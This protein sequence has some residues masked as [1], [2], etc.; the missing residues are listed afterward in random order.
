LRENTQETNFDCLYCID[1]GAHEGELFRANSLASKMFTVYSKIIGV[2]YLWHALALPIHHLNKAGTTEDEQAMQ[3]G[4]AP[5]GH[6]LT[7]VGLLE[8][9]PER[10]AEK[11]ER[12]VDETVLSEVN[13]SQYQLLLYCGKILKKIMNSISQIRAYVYQSRES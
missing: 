3:E 10:L 11:L 1:A 13:I 6:L 7:D 12:E 8:V 5:P 9:D 2:R 4:K